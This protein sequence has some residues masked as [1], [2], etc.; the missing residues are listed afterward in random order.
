MLNKIINKQVITLKMINSKVE[1]KN[2]FEKQKNTNKETKRIVNQLSG[3]IDALYDAN[4]ILDFTVDE[5]MFDE[6]FK[7]NR[8]LLD[9]INTTQIDE[10]VVIN[11]RNSINSITKEIKEQWQFFYSKKTTDMLKTLRFL[12][13]FNK[14]NIGAL[15]QQFA[16]AKNWTGNKETVLL[17]KESMEQANDIIDNLNMN[18]TVTDFFKKMNNGTA[19]L[20]DLNE[21]VLAWIDEKNVKYKIKLKFE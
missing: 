1:E 5:K 15:E 7:T 11:C 10:N 3:L 14:Q 21:E 20:V 12:K 2:N 16:E 19:T 6:L 17:L 13:N 8:D 9:T 18:E 4:Q